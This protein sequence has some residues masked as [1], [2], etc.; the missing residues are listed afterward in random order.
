MVTDMDTVT[1]MATEHRPR[2]RAAAMRIAYCVCVAFAVPAV[3]G[4]WKITPSISVNETAT[5]NVGL[6]NTNQ[7]SDL[8]SDIAPGL[9]IEG[10]GD[11]VKMRFNYQMHNLFYA[12]DSSRNQTQNSLDASGTL[13]ALDD[14]F[15]IDA[16]GRISQQTISAFGGATP[17]GVNT[18]SDN[19]TE[20]ST[21]TLSPYF[22]GRLGGAADYV[23]R[24][25]AK[26]TRSKQGSAFDSDTEELSANLRGVTGLSALGWAFDAD[27]QSHDFSNGRSN[28]ADM[29]RGT[30]IFQFDP[31]FRVSVFGGRESNDYLS[32]NSEKESRTTR[33]AGFEWAPTERTQIAAKREKRFFGDANDFS[34]SHRTAGTAWKYRESKDATVLPNTQSSGGLGTYY[35]LFYSLFESAIPDPTARAAYVNALLLSSGISPTAQLQGGFLSSGVTLQHRK[36]LSFALVGVRNTVTFAANQ[37]ESENLSRAQGMGFY[38]GQNL[39]DVQTIKQKGVSV[40]WSHK[41]T[42]LSSLTGSFARTVSTGSGGSISPETTQRLF[43]VNFTTKLGPNT[44]AGLGARRIVVDG[45][46]NYT[47]NSLTGTLSHQF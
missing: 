25:T 16:T 44:T 32:L 15:F 29:V 38:L 34:F 14:W 6:K 19:T 41:L 45:T 33:G 31:Q 13:E 22:R 47:E 12:N 26:T 37:S 36:E 2:W 23:L 40:N 8:I 28:E 46:S 18:N 10:T 9:R 27:R 20:T 7:E 30:L 24:Y 11:R 42:A 5:D 39:A 35:D 21:Y 17:S 1:G 43:N 4:D 3:A